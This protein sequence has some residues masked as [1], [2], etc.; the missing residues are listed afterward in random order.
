M[1]RPGCRCS[2]HWALVNYDLSTGLDQTQSEGTCRD[3]RDDE[4]KSNLDKDRSYRAL[5]R[6]VSPP[7]RLLDIGCGSG[8][9][10]CVA[11]EAGWQ[12]QGLE[13]SASMA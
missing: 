10:L 12:V 5:S 3:P 9:M 8:R 11:M 6:F 13:L 4:S 7:G 2:T 1:A